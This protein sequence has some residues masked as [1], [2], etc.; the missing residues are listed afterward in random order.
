MKGQYLEM[1]YQKY[2]KQ[3]FLFAFSLSHN[4]EDAEDMVANTFVKAFLSYEEGNLKAWLYVVLKNEFINLY[5]KKKKIIS[6]DRINLNEIE[7]SL[8]V[9]EEYI[10][11]D[12]KRWL[13]RQIYLLKDKEKQ[14]MLLSIQEDL[15]DNTIAN[16]V[17]LTIENVRVI[18]HRVKKKLKDLCIKEGLI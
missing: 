17:G 9:L 3:L 1:I 15:D 4:K 16:I 5:K 14:I 2:Y 8:N 12:K 11:E 7:D 18:K 6:E 10:L 13:Y